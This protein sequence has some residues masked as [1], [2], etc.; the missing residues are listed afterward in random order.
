MIYDLSE[1]NSFTKKEV[2]DESHANI[3]EKEEKRK[4]NEKSFF[5]FFDIMTLIKATYFEDIILQRIMKV[6]RESKRQI[7]MNITRTNLRLELNDY[8]IKND[9]L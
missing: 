7:S 2:N 4:I 9:F 8:N 1:K 3:F 5:D 6:K